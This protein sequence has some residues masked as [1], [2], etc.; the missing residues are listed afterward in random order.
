ML[1]EKL[2][3]LVLNVFDISIY[4]GKNIGKFSHVQTMATDKFGSIT[5]EL[6][7]NGVSCMFSSKSILCD[8]FK[9][10]G[11]WIY[12]CSSRCN[13]S[14]HDVC[15]VT[16]VLSLCMSFI[17]IESKATT[18]WCTKILISTELPNALTSSNSKHNAHTHSHCL[19]QFTE[20]WYCKHSS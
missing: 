10:R 8:I 4:R 6:H 9:L 18:Q 3:A 7:H 17:I 16:E 15:S 13:L 1:R 20:H 5:F 14:E 11:K 2:Y 12:R 19:T